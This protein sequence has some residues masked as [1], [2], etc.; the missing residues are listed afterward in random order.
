MYNSKIYKI[1]KSKHLYKKI[2]IYNNFCKIKKKNNLIFNS[3][4]NNEKKILTNLCFHQKKF[5]TINNFMKINR[6]ALLF[7]I[8]FNKCKLYTKK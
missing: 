7:K 2:N 6:H 3:F 1:I 4:K 8:T 5:K